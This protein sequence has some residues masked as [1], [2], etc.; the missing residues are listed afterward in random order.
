MVGDGF[1]KL[2][3]DAFNAD[4]SLALTINGFTRSNSI[5]PVGIAFPTAATGFPTGDVLA[6]DQLGNLRLFPDKGNAEGLAVLNGAVDMAQSS[7]LKIM[8]SDAFLYKI[9]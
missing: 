5:G 7:L 8:W 6:T 4:F 9:T 3:Q 1:L 2:T